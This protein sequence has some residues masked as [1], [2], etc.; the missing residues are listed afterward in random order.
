MNGKTTI[1]IVDNDERTQT[2]VSDFLVREG[3]IVITARYDQNVLDEFERVHPDLILLDVVLPNEDGIA[4]INQIRSRTVC[5]ILVI[6]EKNNTMD[7]II[8]L[9]MGADDYMGKPF[10]MRE[11]Y[12]RIKANLRLVNSVEKEAVSRRQNETATILH[13]G[14]WYLDLQRHEFLDENKKPMDMTPG[15]IEMLKAFAMSPRKALSRD[16]LFDL[17]RERDYE[18]FDRAV[19]VQISRIRKKIGDD[20]REQP[21]I[22]TI[23]GIGYMLDAE[24]TVIE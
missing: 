9:E 6:S 16:K 21:Y 18:G 3:Y 4:L 19:D 22:K 24:I 12:A 7:K 1:L 5:P 23:R 8:G 11:L 14:Q 10:E 20:H 15:E 2:V 17:T 13:F